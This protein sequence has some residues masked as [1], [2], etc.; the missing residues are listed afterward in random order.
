MSGEA[1]PVRP[2]VLVLG[3]GMARGFA[4]AGVLRALNEA[5]IPI[6]A[7]IGTEMGA[8]VSALYADS[9]FTDTGY[10]PAQGSAPNPPEHNEASK[11]GLAG[12]LVLPPMPPVGTAKGRHPELRFVK[13]NTR[14][15]QIAS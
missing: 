7:V 13:P 9:N 15:A 8:L 1:R 6:G 5:K 2:I 11:G 10:T 12:A 3:P 4:F 14:A